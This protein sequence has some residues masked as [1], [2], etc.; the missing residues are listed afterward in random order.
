MQPALAKPAAPSPVLLAA[1]SALGRLWITVFACVALVPAFGYTTLAFG[2]AI[3]LAS[4][5]PARRRSILSAL[6]ILVCV[7]NLNLKLVGGA[8][9]LSAN[10]VPLGALALGAAWILI[11]STWTRLFA[12]VP[13]WLGRHSLLLLH[14][15]AVAL[16]VVLWALRQLAVI[17]AFA[18]GALCTLVPELLWRSA[19]WI[20]WRGRETGRS[21]IWANL[22]AILPFVGAGG[23]PIGKGPAYL[24]KHEVRDADRL[25]IAQV[26]GV[27]LLA[28]ALL[29][30]AADGVLSCVLWRFKAEWL[31]AW[32]VPARRLLP[33]MDLLLR[34]PMRFPLWQRWACLY[35]ELFHAILVLAVYSHTIVGI[36][37]LLGFHIPRNM[38]SPLLAT[39][40][41]DFW[42]RYYFYFKELLMDFW[43]FPV[44]LRTSRFPVLWRTMLATMSAAFLGNLYYHLVLYWPALAAGN[45]TTFRNQAAAR[46]I[47]CA[48]LAAGLCGSF[49]RSL[50]RRSSV[51]SAP[52]P[53]RVFQVLMVLGFFALIHVWNFIDPVI[54]AARR[55]ALWQA[56][57]PWR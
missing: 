19:Y 43:F 28:L 2:A 23:V 35:G 12:R 21:P 8:A 47:Y 34:L 37:C 51:S 27:K 1:R 5:L 11:L 20:K 49:A 6:A 48:L 40:I 42:G 39:T 54:P 22:F 45:W 44:F 14:G 9:I 7:R 25:A 31:P 29:W 36:F 13:R 46:V 53:R 15:A 57:L 33:T 16:I 4:F 10:S 50:K 3:G 24:A 38:K 56:L 26:E 32:I 18:A 52:I 41:L 30:Q 17:N 55:L